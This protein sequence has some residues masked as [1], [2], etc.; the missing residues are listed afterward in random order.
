M[1]SN[2]D[3]AFPRRISRSTGGCQDFR[4]YWLRSPRRSSQSSAP[5]AKPPVST[6]CSRQ[7]P[8][9]R[10]LTLFFVRDAY[11][12]RSFRMPPLI[13]VTSCSTSSMSSYANRSSSR[14]SSESSDMSLAVANMRGW[15]SP[16]RSQREL[17]QAPDRTVQATG[18]PWY[19]MLGRYRVLDGYVP[20]MEARSWECQSG[21]FRRT[22][23]I[24]SLARQTP[25]A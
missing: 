17:T 21:W 13:D 24:L 11:G 12:S 4:F 18:T 2:F 8:S 5:P 23:E 14:T 10:A 6:G 22:S 9:P 7:I 25:S 15:F 20:Q 19:S 3:A 1:V 16:C